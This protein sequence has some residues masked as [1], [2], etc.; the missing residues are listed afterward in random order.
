MT[1]YSCNRPAYALLVTIQAKILQLSVKF[2]RSY[3]VLRRSVILP[4]IHAQV[5]SYLSAN[6]LKTPKFGIQIKCFL[7]VAVD[8]G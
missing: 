2:A 5:Y 7:D 3:E 4:T 1:W 6:E 8:R